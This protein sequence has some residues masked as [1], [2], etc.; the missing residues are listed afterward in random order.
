[1]IAADATTVVFCEV[2]TRRAGPGR[3]WDNLHERK[4]GQVRRMAVA[5]LHDV[6]DRPRRRSVRFDAVGV[7]VDAA[8][9]LEALEHLEAAF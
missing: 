7:T 2:K 5:Y 9:R 3:P 4:R 1:V 6:D 8:G